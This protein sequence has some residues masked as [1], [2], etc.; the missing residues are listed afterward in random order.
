MKRASLLRAVLF[1]AT[2][3]SVSCAN[4]RPVWASQAAQDDPSQLRRAGELAR[5]GKYD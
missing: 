1:L 2:V 5:S 3:A 4:D